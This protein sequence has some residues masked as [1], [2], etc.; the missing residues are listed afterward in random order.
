MTK[1]FLHSCDPGHG[2]LIVS[3]ADMADLGLTEADIS[4]YSYRSGDRIA[5]EED[6]DA[7]T[8]IEA[9]KAKYGSFENTTDYKGAAIRSWR[10][11]GTKVFTYD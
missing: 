4:G 8:F 9:Y 5:L 7:S 1:T 2:W 11:F 10:S 6:C 3:P